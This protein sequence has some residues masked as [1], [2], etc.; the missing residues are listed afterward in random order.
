[1]VII[2]SLGATWRV[3][4]ARRRYNLR[5]VSNQLRSNAPPRMGPADRARVARASIQNRRDIERRFQQ[6]N[7]YKAFQNRQASSA[8]LREHQRRAVANRDYW[9]EVERLKR[10]DMTARA[11]AAYFDPGGQ[12]A[13]RQAYIDR[14]NAVLA[15]Q[16]TLPHAQAF[17][18]YVT[19][20]QPPGLAPLPS[21][22]KIQPTPGATFTPVD[23]IIPGTPGAAEANERILDA[24][25]RLGIQG[26][27][28]GM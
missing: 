9:A 25:A 7:R 19:K 23:P 28:Y 21:Q 15:H 10:D 24:K 1:M 22:M 5:L 8:L 13:K 16:A 14:I 12:I 27:Y 26:L 11:V 2:E 3:P 6:A 18:D 4:E 20:T 17:H